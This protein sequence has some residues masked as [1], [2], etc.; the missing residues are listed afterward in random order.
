[1]YTRY[2]NK[3]EVSKGSTTLINSVVVGNL[4]L[5]HE[6]GVPDET[7]PLGYPE[8]RLAVSKSCRGS[9]A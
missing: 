2:G 8:S 9:S 6:L 1:M 3:F 4:L 7:Q 5:F